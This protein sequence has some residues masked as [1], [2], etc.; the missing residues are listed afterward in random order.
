MAVPTRAEI[1]EK[2]NELKTENNYSSVTVQDWLEAEGVPSEDIEKIISD[3]G[4]Y[5]NIK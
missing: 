5:E 3:L 2:I 1:L 4:S